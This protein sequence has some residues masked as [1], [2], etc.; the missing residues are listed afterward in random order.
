MISH[1]SGGEVFQ[2]RIKGIFFGRFFIF[3]KDK[4]A[5]R[6][7]GVQILILLLDTRLLYSYIWLIQKQ[8]LIL[9]SFPFKSRGRIKR[10][11]GLPL[12]AHCEVVAGSRSG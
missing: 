10:T 6:E 4:A 1:E 11:E 7:N 3:S 5:S 8:V 12:N 2:Y 9:L